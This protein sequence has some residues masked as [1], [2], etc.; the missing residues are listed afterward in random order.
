MAGWGRSKR[1]LRQNKEREAG[2]GALLFI[3]WMLLISHC[4]RD[5]VTLPRSRRGTIYARCHSVRNNYHR[6]RTSRGNARCVLCGAAIARIAS[7][8]HRRCR[9]P[10][11][12]EDSLEMCNQAMADTRR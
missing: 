11:G 8:L 5:L 3:L 6:V 12:R 7:L 4:R 1:W 9:S 10:K 2:E